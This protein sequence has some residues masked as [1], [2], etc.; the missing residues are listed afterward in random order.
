MSDDADDSDAIRQRKRDRLIDA[1]DEPSTPQEPI[2][3][4]GESLADLVDR[5]DVVLVDYYADW[6]GPCKMLE[7][8]VESLAADGVVVAKVDVDANQSLARERGIRGVPTLE[9]YADGEQVERLS[10]VQDEGTL[11]TLVARYE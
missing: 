8:T 11:R 4:D 1:H 2:H 6:C 7:P 3:V 9:L 5:H 10:G